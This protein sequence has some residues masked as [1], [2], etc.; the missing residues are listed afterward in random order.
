MP[1]PSRDENEGVFGRGGGGRSACVVAEPGSEFTFREGEGRKKCEGN[2]WDER[3]GNTYTEKMCGRGWFGMH[4]V[5]SGQCL[6]VYH[7]SD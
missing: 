4:M 5:V 1:Y 6:Q 2:R 7:T 3:K